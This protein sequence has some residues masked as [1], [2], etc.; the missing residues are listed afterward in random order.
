MDNVYLLAIC[1]GH[2]MNGHLVSKHIKKI[3]VSILEFED[4]RL[5]SYRFS[6]KNCG[7]IFN[8]PNE[9]ADKSVKQSLI[10]QL[11][12]KVFNSINK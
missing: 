4:K 3:L 9:V 8:L 12:L 6:D 7:S 1:D 5:V 11:L 10:K 2:G